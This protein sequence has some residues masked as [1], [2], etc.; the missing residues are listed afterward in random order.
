MNFSLFRFLCLS[1]G[2]STLVACANT[3]TPEEPMTRRITDVDDAIAALNDWASK[4]P[5]RD[6][7]YSLPPW[8]YA[9]ALP[10]TDM[11]WRMGGYE[12]YL[13]GFKSWFRAAD[14]S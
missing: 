12:N 3:Q 5:R 2:A 10:R 6:A 4:N 8:E 7:D 13:D 1:F 14:A 9:P 11:G